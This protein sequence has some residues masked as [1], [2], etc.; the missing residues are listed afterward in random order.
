M[1]VQSDEILTQP[2]PE[3]TSDAARE[4]SVQLEA[5][6]IVAIPA[7]GIQRDARIMIVDDESYN[8]LV[9][10][11]FLQHAGY[12]NFITSTEPQNVVDLMKREVPDIVLLDIM[13]PGV[14]GIDI[15]RSM[16]SH[17][18]LSMIPVVIL[19]ASPEASVK[20]QALEL[21][22]TDFL[23]KPVDPSELVLRVRNVLGAKA[24]FDDLA[25]YSVNLEAQVKQR[26]REL[27]RS[28]KHI[29][30]CLARACEFRDN[31]TGQHIIRVGK[32]AG[33]IARELG[34]SQQQAEALDQAAQLHDVGKIAIP[35]SI[36]HKPGKLDPEQYEFM[37]KHAGF[38]KQIIECMPDEEWVSLKKH[39]KIGSHFLDVKSSPLMRMAARIALTH[40]EHWDGGGYPLGL[41]GEDIPLEG[42]IT[43]VS[44][45]YDALSS[46][47]PYKKPFPREKC[48]QMLKEKRGAQFDPDVL[49]AFFNRIEEIV[50]VQI[51]YADTE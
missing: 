23:S 28:Q 4:D 18:D 45:V 35:D 10:R 3:S 25:D 30:F 50:E 37:Q 6:P 2:D 24:N 51:R 36:L 12:V 38:G 34:F 16:K 46:R 49:D 27:E 19:T 41:Q 22:A 14:S 9:V 43:A 29:I 13:M 42:R 1:I 40:H 5:T 48:F 26:T 15:L 21:G 31:E 47:R 17:S 20:T 39:T 44:D 32:F 7:A 11:K 33:I 8:L